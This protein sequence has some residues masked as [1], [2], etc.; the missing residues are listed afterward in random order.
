MELRVD[1]AGLVGVVLRVDT[2]GVRDV[3]VVGRLLVVAR[4][5]RLGRGMVM[6]RGMLVM[7]GR[8]PVVLDLFLMGHDLFCG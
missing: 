7:L 6:A 5:V 1:L 4:R 3:G 8:V 2:V